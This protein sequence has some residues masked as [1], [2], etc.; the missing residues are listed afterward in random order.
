MSRA[1]GRLRIDGSVLEGAELATMHR[2]LVAARVVEADLRRVSDVAPLAGALGRPLP[3]KTLERRLEQSV[4]PDGT[5]LDT[6]SPR[7]AA[8][9]REVHA[10]R[11]RLHPEA[12]V[13]APRT[14]RQHRAG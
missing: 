10:A 14:R 2:I 5:L 11:D 3:D 1:L 13:D 7:L 9:R 4:D 6:A 12:R 8:A